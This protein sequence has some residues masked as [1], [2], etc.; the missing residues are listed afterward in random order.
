MWA[1]AWAGELLGLRGGLECPDLD[2]LRSALDG[3]RGA[4]ER[5]PTKHVR[6]HTHK[7]KPLNHFTV[8]PH[9]LSPLR[10]NIRVAAPPSRRATPLAAAPRAHFFLCFSS[11]ATS[12][13]R[14]SGGQ[15]SWPPV[16]LTSTAAAAVGLSFGFFRVPPA[17]YRHAASPRVTHA[18]AWRFACG[19][20]RDRSSVNGRRRQPRILSVTAQWSLPGPTMGIC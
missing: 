1:G 16:V 7:L 20:T 15:N 10:L 6:T 5:Q 18:A 4:L 3:K 11:T 13:A 8:V 17:A 2:Y 9:P 12:G 14:P 19:Q